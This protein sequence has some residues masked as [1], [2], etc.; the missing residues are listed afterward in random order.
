M[1][2]LQ[3]PSNNHFGSRSQTSALKKDRDLDHAHAM[4]RDRTR[5]GG[6][7]HALSSYVEQ[8]RHVTVMLTDQNACISKWVRWR[9]WVLTHVIF[10]KNRQKLQK[11]DLNR[12]R[13][14][15]FSKIDLNG[16]ICGTRR[17]E[18]VRSTSAGEGTGTGIGTGTGT[19]Y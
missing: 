7:T 9:T 3:K 15:R 4:G 8:N 19:P 11:I 13:F 10:G 14:F 1:H 6:S 16:S 2:L 12:L 5:V 17:I 18:M